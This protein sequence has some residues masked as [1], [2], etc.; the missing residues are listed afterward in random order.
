MTDTIAAN[1]IVAKDR[2]C[3][4]QQLEVYYVARKYGVSADAV[5][6]VISATKRRRRYPWRHIPAISSNKS[7]VP[8]CKQRAMFLAVAK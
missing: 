8:G 3:R 1:I 7:H 6:N 2:H 5:R 4:R